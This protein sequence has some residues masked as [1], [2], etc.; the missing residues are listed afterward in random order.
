MRL[1]HLPRIISMMVFRVSFD[2][3]GHASINSKSAGSVIAAIGDTIVLS[4]F[5]S[6][7]D[8]K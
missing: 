3:R 1:N 5:L 4:L 7:F 6:C 2:N 8:G